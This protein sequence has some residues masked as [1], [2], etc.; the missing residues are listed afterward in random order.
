MAGPIQ[1]MFAP[2][3]GVDTVN[4]RPKRYGDG[5]FSQRHA[6]GRPVSLGRGRDYREPVLDSKPSRIL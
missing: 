4:L 3:L 5:L 2:I 1:M 6:R